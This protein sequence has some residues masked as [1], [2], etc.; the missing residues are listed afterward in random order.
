[1][2]NFQT[3]ASLSPTQQE[4]KVPSLDWEEPLEKEMATTSVFLPKKSHGQR[5]LASYSPWG[6]K[7]SDVTETPNS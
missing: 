6:H 3:G 7:E 1:M 5:S 2:V 4:L